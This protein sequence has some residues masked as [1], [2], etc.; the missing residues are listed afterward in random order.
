MLLVNAIFPFC[1]GKAASAGAASASTATLAASQTLSLIPAS[2]PHALLS[3]S[4]SAWGGD[5]SA[6]RARVRLEVGVLDVLVREVGVQL[7]GRDV[8]VAE[9][10]LHRAQV[11]AARQ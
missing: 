6:P 5:K 9:H 7:R 1:P 3:Y 10:L 11:A 4:F 2:H 8:G